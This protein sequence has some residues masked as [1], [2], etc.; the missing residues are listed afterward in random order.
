MPLSS[1]PNESNSLVKTLVGENFNEVVLGG[2][3]DVVVFFHSVWCLDCQEIL[4]EYEKLAET[5]SKYNDIV[6]AKI[7]CFHNEGEVIP[8][9]IDGEP[10]LRVFKSGSGIKAGV[11]FEGTYVKK[12]LETFLSKELDLSS[13]DL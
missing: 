8:E 5:F 4:T 10:V 2:M 1:I 7:D 13:E 9:G 3:K 6:F 11:D 12:E